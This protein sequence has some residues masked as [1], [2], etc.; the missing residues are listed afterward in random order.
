MA[1]ITSTTSITAN[2]AGP[3]SISA[4]TYACAVRGVAIISVTASITPPR[5]TFGA[6][7]GEHEAATEAAAA[8]CAIQ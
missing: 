7:T 2:A 1:S 5:A 8:L 4:T 6:A 3:A